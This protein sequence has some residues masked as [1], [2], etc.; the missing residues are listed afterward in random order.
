M[1]RL[2]KKQTQFAFMVAMLILFVYWRGYGISMGEAWRTREQAEKYA[3]EGKGIA[4]SLHTLR[5]AVDLN[6]FHPETGAYLTDAA[7]YE[8]AGR[9]WKSLGGAWGGDFAS[10]DANHFSLAYEGR[11]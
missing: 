4:N 8:F 3:K 2:V 10:R 6:L 1:T 11:K 5:L 9:F 7:D